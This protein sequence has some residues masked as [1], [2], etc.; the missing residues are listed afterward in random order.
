MSLT[1]KPIHVVSIFAKIVPGHNFSPQGVR[2]M[3]QVAGE[4]AAGADE[5]SRMECSKGSED[6][7][8]AQSR[9]EREDGCAS[10]SPASSSGQRCQETEHAHFPQFKCCAPVPVN[11]LCVGHNAPAT[12]GFG[13]SVSHAV[14]VRVFTDV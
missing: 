10:A 6:D 1:T 7:R 3:A 12:N 4:D 5:M 2:E 13:H 11:D 14:P 9:D 8:M